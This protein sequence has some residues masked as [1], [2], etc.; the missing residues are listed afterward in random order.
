ME[1]NDS[2]Q[3]E[4]TPTSVARQILSA[5]VNNLNAEVELKQVA[6]R[7]EAALAEP[8]GLSEKSL[9]E[10]LFVGLDP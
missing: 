7:L 3:D 4:L 1:T 9:R 2:E 6:S 8:K 10:A 5:F